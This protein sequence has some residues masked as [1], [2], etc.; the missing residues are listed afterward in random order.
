MEF[1]PVELNPDKLWISRLGY[2]DPKRGASLI[3]LD[4]ILL[5]HLQNDL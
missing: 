5:F 4:E 3:N 2:A 1:N